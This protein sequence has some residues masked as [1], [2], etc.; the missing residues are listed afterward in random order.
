MELPAMS[1]RAYRDGG[2]LAPVEHH[3]ALFHKWMR[4]MLGEV[5]GEVT[6]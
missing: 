5:T 2:V 4:S 6:G 3:M 1:S